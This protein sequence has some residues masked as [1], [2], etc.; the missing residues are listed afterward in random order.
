MKRKELNR[1][2]FLQNVFKYYLEINELQLNG[3]SLKKAESS[4]LLSDIN[5]HITQN[6]LNPTFFN[7]LLRM[8]EYNKT[9]IKFKCLLDFYCLSNIYIDKDRSSMNLK[10]VIFQ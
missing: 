10:T 8:Q 2:I 1:F 7:Q 6:I 9:R 3:D 5:F 4:Q